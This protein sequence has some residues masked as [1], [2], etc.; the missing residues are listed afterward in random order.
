MVTLFELL[1]ELFDLVVELSSLSVLL[2]TRCLAQAT[3]DTSFN[4]S[5]LIN[6]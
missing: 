5:I 3:L 6:K 4:D 2:K 1:E